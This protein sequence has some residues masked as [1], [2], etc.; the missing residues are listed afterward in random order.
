[1]GRKPKPKTPEPSGISDWYWYST[2]DEGG[3][4]TELVTVYTENSEVKAKM[5]KANA[6]YYN[7]RNGVHYVMTRDSAEHKKIFELL[8]LTPKNEWKGNNL[9]LVEKKPRKKRKK[10]GE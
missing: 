7:G 5:R 8:K 1:M 6:Q 10:K 3:K 9:H 4:T 2:T